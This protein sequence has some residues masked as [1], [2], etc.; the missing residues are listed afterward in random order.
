MSAL[1]SLSA[2]RI[3]AWLLSGAR[4]Q[5]EH[6]VRGTERGRQA[7]DACHLNSFSFYLSQEKRWRTQRFISDQRSNCQQKERNDTRLRR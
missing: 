6:P 2:H 3:H 1:H 4:L 5:G 7:A